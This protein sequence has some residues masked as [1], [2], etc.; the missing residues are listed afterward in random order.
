MEKMENISYS[1]KKEMIN[2]YKNEKE[3][4]KS[5]IL[6]F[7]N[8]PEEKF[9]QEFLFCLLTPQSNAQKSWSAVQE[10]M[11]LNSFN[12]KSISLILKTKTRFH[13]VKTLRILKA[14]QTWKKIQPLLKNKNIPQLRKQIMYVTNGYGLKESAHFLRNIGLS[15][16]KIAILDRHILKNLHQMNIIESPK[17]KS[18]KQYLEIEENFI[19]F[20]RE[21]EIPL[22]E[23]DLV[24]WSKENGEIFK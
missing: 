10:L 22:D 23:L 15:N 16:N 8:L 2:F 11:R 5:R 4:I 6:N 21:I 12:E 3:M 9:Y 7:K 24:L 17:I 20:S 19:N 18:L 1:T 13:N 14:P